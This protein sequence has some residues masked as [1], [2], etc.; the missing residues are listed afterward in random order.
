MKALLAR[1]RRRYTIFK[2]IL[3]RGNQIERDYPHA[4]LIGIG[5]NAIN[6][7]S[8]EHALDLFIFWHAVTRYGDGRSD[9]PRALSRKLDYLKKNVEKDT[10]LPEDDRV[11]VR[12][13]RLSMAELAELR[14]DYTHSFTSIL[15]PTAN[16]DFVRLRYEGK[17]IVPVRK[18]YSI[19]DLSD[20]GRKIASEHHR[21]AP[22]VKKH[23]QDWMIANRNLFMS[24][25]TEKERP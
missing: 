20:L 10:S 9:H 17:N 11:T 25:S 1:F 8:I 3:E 18:V 22:F 7:A 19:E 14:H 15:D 23:C 21:V 13:I 6:W 16:W 4:A 5:A 2:A 12:N 24:S